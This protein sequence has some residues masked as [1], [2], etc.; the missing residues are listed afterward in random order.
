[1]ATARSA[2][3]STP[4]S[5]VNNIS[6]STNPVRADETLLSPYQGILALSGA[7]WGLAADRLLHFHV[8]STVVF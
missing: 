3:P 6:A 1:M 4:L 5:P 2:A 7:L 8:P